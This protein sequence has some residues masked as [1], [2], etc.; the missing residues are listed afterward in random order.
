[1]GVLGTFLTVLTKIFQVAT[2]AGP[3][4]EIA[5]QIFKP[6]QKS[7]PEKLAILRQAIRQSLLSSEILVGKQIVDEAAL[8]SAIGDF[9]SGIAKVQKA[10]AHP[11]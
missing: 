11:A 9:A 3:L 8:D 2:L 6:G 1:M 7:G 5:G 4:A 10:V